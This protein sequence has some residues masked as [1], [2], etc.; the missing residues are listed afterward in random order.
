MSEFTQCNYCT[1]QQL[2]Q[3]A[4]KQGKIV[5]VQPGGIGVNVYIRSSK[6]ALD[7]R[8]PDDG[9]KQWVASFMQLTR[10]CVC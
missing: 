2:K 10:H 5:D 7:T 1:F 9:N 6:E 3:R 4:R 8:S